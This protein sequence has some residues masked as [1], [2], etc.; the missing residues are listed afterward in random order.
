MQLLSIYDEVVEGDINEVCKYGA[1]GEK[2]KTSNVIHISPVPDHFLTELIF[3]CES[4]GSVLSYIHI[5]DKQNS[6]LLIKYKFKKD[7]DTI[8]NSPK[9]EIDG[10][11]IEIKQSEKTNINSNKKS[12]YTNKMLT[13]EFK[14]GKE[15]MSEFCKQMKKHFKI[16]YKP[17]ENTENMVMFYFKNFYEMLVFY[18][19]YH[20]YI[21]NGWY[22]TTRRAKELIYNGVLYKKHDRYILNKSA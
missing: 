9:I 3:Y 19:Q 6:F 10:L 1:I 11:R 8:L 14:K 2:L 18:E 5:N 22:I 4:F 12:A 15:L 13:V 7:K 20:V 16:G 21:E 17:I